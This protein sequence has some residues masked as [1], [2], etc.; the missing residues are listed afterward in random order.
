[1]KKF[2]AIVFALIFALSC[3]ATAFAA[4]NLE[5]P[6]CHKA[7]FATEKDYNKHLESECPVR[8]GGN[9]D[10]SIAPMYCEFGCG[11]AFYDAEQYEI[12]VTENCPNRKTT[13]GQEVENFFLGLDYEDFTNVLDKITEALT[14][15]GLPGILNTIIGLLE[16]GVIALLGAI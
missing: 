11:A 7:D 15:I 1:M 5:C 4:V 13:W 6:D 12:H 16:E 8:F 9:T 2:L 14:G 3:A 10:D